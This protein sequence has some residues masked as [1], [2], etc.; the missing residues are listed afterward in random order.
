MGERQRAYKFGLRK[1]LVFFTTILAIIT[2]STSAF[3]IYFV[4]PSFF[5]GISPTTFTIATLLLG[6]IWSGILAY[7]AA[8][9]ITRPLKKLENAVIDASEGNIGIDVELKNS[10]DEIYSLGAAFNQMLHNMREIVQ[11]IDRNF[12]QTNENVIAIS[13]KSSRA[14]Q[15]AESVAHTISE[16]SAGA[17]SSAISIQ[18][19]AESVEDITRI[20]EEVQGRARASEQTSNDMLN[21][22]TE[23]KKVI[24]SLVDGIEKLARGNRESLEAVNRL[25]ENAQKVE[26]I[27]QL[28]GDIAAQTNLLA[29][30]ASIEAAR[31]G[32]H[33]KGFAVV[34]EEVR[35]LADESGTAVK[36]ISELIQNIQTEVENVV[37]RITEQVGHANEE[38]Q[39]GTKTNAVIEE[40][41]GTIHSMAEA[42]KDITGLVDKQMESVH[43]TSQQSQE[44]AAIAEQ[45]SAGA[46]EVTE[47]TKEQAEVMKSIEELALELKQSAS[48]LKT[49]ITRFH[50]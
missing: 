49:T 21:G 30:N 5:A 15:Q 31:A 41:T 23:S 28:V 43:E 24:Q 13:N 8:A 2:Y 10:H 39:K 6:I 47:A 1:K 42:V 16:I 17:E 38:A 19:T 33:G 32:E 45:T 9:F 34:A 22:L 44:V 27:I 25:K 20:A 37:K 12:E 26:Q 18:T 3:F 35:N 48:Q 46:E 40:M 14:F 50:L 11:S 36:G 4:R 7:F 29:L